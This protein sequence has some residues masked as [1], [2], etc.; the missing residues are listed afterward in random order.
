[1]SFGKTI[2]SIRRN[3]HISIDQVTNETITKSSYSR[4]VT[5]KT[6]PSINNFLTILNNLHVNFEEFLYIDRGYRPDFIAETSEKIRQYALKNNITKIQKIYQT[7][8]VYHKEEPNNVVYLH[9][10]CVSRLILDCLQ[11]KTL[12]PRSRKIIHEYLMNCEIWTHY[13]HTLFKSTIFIFDVKTV[14]A[15]EKRI[16]KNLDNYQLMHEYGNESFRTMI[17]MLSFFIYNKQLKPAI[18]IITKLN[19]FHLEMFMIFEK[20]LYKLFSGTVFML[21]NQPNGIDDI[22]SALKVFELTDCKDYLVASIVFIKNIIK[23]YD[24]H[25][26]KI[27]KILDEFSN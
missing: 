25:N 11:R 14:Q 10:Q 22:Y 2:Q 12:D 4:F 21:T 23:L 6:Q 8:S 19:D 9:L 3:K 7:L 17:I 1:M 15:M 24:F 27:D 5:G 18:D 26:S 20:N 16:I 13:E